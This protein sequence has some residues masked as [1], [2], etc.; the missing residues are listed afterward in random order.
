[1][2]KFWLLLLCLM[3]AL[4]TG[5]ALADEVP[6]EL[7]GS[8]SMTGVEEAYFPEGTTINML[9]TETEVTMTIGVYGTTQ[10]ETMSYTVEGDTIVVN[11]VADEYKIEGNTLWLT[12]G[13][14]TMIF[15]RE[16]AA[17][18]AAAADDGILGEWDIVSITGEGVGDE[19][20]QSLEMIKAMGGTMTIKFTETEMVMKAVVFGQN[21]EEAM[22]YT[23][24]GNEITIDGDA[25]PYTLDGNTLTIA[26]EEACMVLQRV[27]TEAEAAEGADLLWEEGSILGPWNVVEFFGDEDAAQSMELIKSMGGSVTVN[28][29]E[30]EMILAMSIFGE[31]M[32]EVTEYVIVGDTIVAEDGE[33][34]V[35]V[36]DGTT[37][38]IGSEEENGMLLQR[39]EIPME[40]A[41]VVDVA[42]PVDDGSVIGEWTLVDMVGSDDVTEMW[43]MMKGMGA[44]I[45]MTITEDSVTMVTTVFGESETESFGCT[46][47]G[48][49]LI[50]ETGYAQEFTL[51]NGRLTLMED[52]MG[53]VFERK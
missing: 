48:N 46:I 9:F 22:P 28:F 16:G 15:T 18:A 34:V 32:E 3:M 41:E 27:G 39:P 25:V 8:W 36:L 51:E 1:M 43:A 53:M 12:E 31:T 13:D 38:T 11:G 4:T 17:P 47:E 2:K 49:M 29:T 26:D 37:L 6:A 30:T 33:P 10:A 42:E 40:N 45:E 7:L 20:S 21:I 14:I 35:F 52:G 19:I 50:D 5:V 23:I 24:V 44:S